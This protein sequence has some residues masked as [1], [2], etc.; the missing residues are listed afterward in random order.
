[1]SCQMKISF[2]KPTAHFLNFVQL[3]KWK[4]SNELSLSNSNIA[5]ILALLSHPCQLTAIQLFSM[6]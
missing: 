6:T 2:D 3:V 1:M 4:L 5:L